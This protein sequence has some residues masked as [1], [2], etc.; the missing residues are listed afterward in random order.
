MSRLLFLSL[1]YIYAHLFLS[2]VG[3][4]GGGQGSYNEFSNKKDSRDSIMRNYYMEYDTTITRIDLCDSLD[5]NF[6]SVNDLVISIDYSNTGFG[7]NLICDVYYLVSEKNN[8]VQEERLVGLSNPK[9]DI[10]NRF[11]YSI[12][13]GRSNTEA[14]SYKWGHNGWSEFKSFEIL[15]NVKG[16]YQFTAVFKDIAGKVISEKQFNGD[17]PP[18]TFFR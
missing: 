16:K 5:L 13:Y 8:Y 18:D 3:L 4:V 7:N 14:F 11:I 12:Y 15:R 9:F 6:D 10:A 17:F 2:L 1:S